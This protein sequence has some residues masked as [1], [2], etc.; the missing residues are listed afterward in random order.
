VRRRTE[1]GGGEAF[2]ANTERIQVKEKV[3]IH[4]PGMP[5]P[6]D[7]PEGEFIGAMAKPTHEGL[8]ASYAQKPVRGFMQIDALGLC[9]DGAVIDTNFLFELRNSD[10]PVRVQIHEGTTRGEVLYY[11]IEIVKMLKVDWYRLDVVGLESYGSRPKFR[12]E[13]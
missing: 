1:I 11:L 10:T 2:A 9:E 6:E 8:L 12:I 13:R 5:Q 3:T 4:L 7:L